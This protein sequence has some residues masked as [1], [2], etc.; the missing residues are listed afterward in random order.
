MRTADREILQAHGIQKPWLLDTQEKL[1]HRLVHWHTTAELFTPKKLGIRDLPTCNRRCFEQLVQQVVPSHRQTIA[2]LY[3]ALDVLLKATSP[4]IEAEKGPRSLFETCLKQLPNL[5]TAEQRQAEEEDPDTDY[6]MSSIIYNELEN[7]GTSAASGWRPLRHLVRAH[8]IQHLS[9]AVRDGV[10]PI[11]IA[12][13]L[14]VLLLQRK[15]YPE[16]QV[17]TESMLDIM[18]PELEPKTS[19]TLLFDDNAPIALSTLD[20]VAT[21]SK[22][23]GFKYAQLAHLFSNGKLPVDWIACPDMKECWSSVIFSATRKDSDS[24]QAALLLKTILALAFGIPP[25]QDQ[26]I[27]RL[28]VEHSRVQSRTRAFNHRVDSGIARLSTR[29]KKQ[30]LV[31]HAEKTILNILTVLSSASILQKPEIPI[32]EEIGI[33]ALKALTLKHGCPELSLIAAALPRAYAVMKASDSH[34]SSMTLASQLLSAVTCSVND[35]LLSE[36]GAF[37]CNVARCCGKAMSQ[38]PF[39][40]LQLLV[41]GLHSLQR[42][43]PNFSAHSLYENV[44]RAAAFEF[45]EWTGDRRH[46]E[47]ALELDRKMKQGD[48]RS[49]QPP[50]LLQ[51]PAIHSV[52][53]QTGGRWEGYRWEEGISEWVAK[54]PASTLK[55]LQSDIPQ[56]SGSLDGVEELNCSTKA[57]SKVQGFDDSPEASPCSRKRKRGSVLCEEA[58]QGSSERLG[59]NVARGTSET[60]ACSDVIANVEDVHSEADELSASPGAKRL[61]RG[62]MPP[63]DG[64]VT[65]PRRRGAAVASETVYTV[66]DGS[67]D[68]LS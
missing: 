25:Q 11:Q 14:V 17:I 65:A 32:L 4:D 33:E 45:G 63:K 15:A 40:F 5:I 46:L 42:H 10:I 64:S 1:V 54:T 27:H 68:E 37:I 7:L 28:R 50:I 56:A 16:A 26:E 47:W 20:L 43:V 44:A 36:A 38:S 49:Q 23:N 51:A 53:D 58:A 9:A 29:A 2:G 52:S 62:S 18:E 59:N 55:G 13:A 21:M 60:G 6:D 19:D 3:M 67:E 41:Q 61:R 24:P 35:V 8:G 66:G 30:K 57:F 12:R 39:E 34:N 22:S 31:P 48:T